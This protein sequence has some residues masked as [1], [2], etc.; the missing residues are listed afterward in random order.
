MTTEMHKAD[1][2]HRLVDMVVEEVSLVDRAANKHRFLIVKRD[3]A[4]DDDKT[5]NTTPAEASPPTAPTA[6]LDD[7][8]ALNAA[9]AALESLTGLVELLGE[10]GADQA[11]ARLAGLAEELRSVAMQL[12]ERTDGDGVSEADQVV[13]ARVKTEPATFA[14]NVAAAKQAVARL[15]EL[16]K[17]VPAKTDNKPAEPKPEPAPAAKAVATD[18]NESLAKLAESFRA[19]SETVKEQQQRLGRVEK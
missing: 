4:M 13:E 6:K 11:D 1:G 12:L 18:V 10:L 15:G 3:E 14:A 16:A 9:L 19:L 2:V 17:Q 8:S 7:N 5:Q